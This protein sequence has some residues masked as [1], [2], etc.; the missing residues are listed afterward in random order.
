M[1]TSASSRIVSSV[2][3]ASASV[4][5]CACA[6]AGSWRTCRSPKLKSCPD[7]RSV[8]ALHEPRTGCGAT[9]ANVAAGGFPPR[10]IC[11]TMNLS[12]S[13]ARSMGQPRR[14]ISSD[15]RRNEKRLA[16]R[17]CRET[18]VAMMKPANLWPRHDRAGCGG[19]NRTAVRRIF[20]EPEMRAGAMVVAQVRRQDTAQVRRV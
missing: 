13:Q 1:R 16:D 5:R 12:V 3:R 18:F 15:T 14:A 9:R 10:G 7:S 20:L 17:L 6:N 2:R 19:E 4:S 11:L 8:R